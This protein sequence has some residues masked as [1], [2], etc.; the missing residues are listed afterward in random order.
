M[1]QPDY[2]QY[3]NEIWGW[4]D[5]LG[6][7][8]PI[9]AIASNI[10][11]GTNPPYSAT[12]FF[13]LYPNF[14]GTPTTIT[15]TV[16]GTTATITN[17]SSI[18]GLLAGQY[19]SGVGIDSGSTIVSAVGSTIVLSKPTIAAGNPVQLTVYTNPLVPTAVINAYI[20]LATSS[21]FQ[22][23]WC[24]M[25][26]VAMGLYIA[27]FLTLWMTAQSTPSNAVASQVATAGLA[28]GVTTSQSAGDVSFAVQP[29]LIENVGAW[30]LTA[31]GQQLATF[32]LVIGSGSMLVW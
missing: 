5:E 16:D 2:N 19:I 8:I 4:P 15:G 28:Q 6:C 27:H 9:A 1:A 22:A 12:D 18:A 31:Y 3:Y 13:S 21:I 26:N 17:V 24:E 25:W 7:A 23:R 29:I 30:N 11:V 14:G 10:I 32:A 20:Y